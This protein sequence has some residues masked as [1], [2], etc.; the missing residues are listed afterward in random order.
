MQQLLSCSVRNFLFCFLR[1]P[2]V[3]LFFIFQIADKQSEGDP[4]MVIGCSSSGVELPWG[5]RILDGDNCLVSSSNPKPKQITRK[6]EKKNSFVDSSDSPARQNVGC[7]RQ[8]KPRNGP[9]HRKKIN[10]TP[11]LKS[12]TKKVMRGHD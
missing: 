7:Y 8:I 9:S 3:S 4:F 1:Y 10:R 6:K 2:F 5:R 11:V 12:I